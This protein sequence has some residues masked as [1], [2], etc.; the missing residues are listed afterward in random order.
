MNADVS[1]LD[2]FGTDEPVAERRLLIAGPLS[3]IL[4]DGNLRTICFAGVELVRAINYLAR[5]SSWGTLKPE[6]SD[7]VVSE[8]ATAF[9][10]GYT[11]LC[12]SPQGAFSYRMHM[13]GEASGRLTVEAEGIALDDFPT[14]R[15]GFVVLHPAEAAGCPLTI[16]HSDG[17]IEETV[18][19]QS[20]SPDQPA[21]DIASLTHRPAPGVSCTVE[22]EGD[23]FEMEDQRNWADA[24]F[25][26]YVRPL[27]KPRPYIIARGEKDRQRIVVTMD[28]PIAAKPANTAAAARLVL[29]PAAGRMPSMALFLDAD[30]LPSAL[31]NTASLG[32]AQDVIVRFDADRGHDATT[33]SQA[34]DLARS[35]GAH[36]AIEAV[37]NAID[38]QAEAAI[39]VGAIRSSGVEPSAVL[40]SPRREFKTRPSNALPAGERPIAELASALRAAGVKASIGAGTPS[41][42]TEFNRNPPTGDCDFV[43]FSVASVVHA[44][45]DLSVMETLGAYPSV[46]A[47]AQKLCPGKPI[48]LGPCTLGMRHNPYGA[49]VAANH[50]R[51]RLPAAADDPRHGALFGAAFATGVAM[52]AAAAG[53]DRLILAAPAGRFGLVN[54]TGAPRPLQVVHAELARAAGAERFATTIDQPGLAAVAFRAGAVIRIL[55]ANLTATEIPLSLPDDMGMIGLLDRN[56]AWSKPPAGQT[57]LG[58][59]RTTL[60]STR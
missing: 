30:D 47:S 17:R 46:I 60:L 35:I 1:A 14:N 3:V 59:Y 13:K 54:E 26:T 41:F 53:V 9:D 34:A 23:A 24:S 39:L 5:D 6:L 12:T 58:P 15:T 36:L 40:V 31:A 48:W 42:F 32:T 38:P 29:G 21:F 56:A 49:A 57:A 16:E 27:S 18:F 19:P 50:A 55:V 37:F 44:A 25:K 22:M 45:D 20:I 10:V 11:G 2:L 51:V 52:Q 43:F 33:L 7:M 4:E 28:A 8:N